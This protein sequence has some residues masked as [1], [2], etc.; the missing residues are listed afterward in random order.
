[1]LFF[2][3]VRNYTTLP[4]KREATFPGQQYCDSLNA[5]FINLKY[6]YQHVCAKVAE[7]LEINV[8]LKGKIKEN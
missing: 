1:M 5:L 7:I 4:K 3:K 8:E 2:W 6:Q